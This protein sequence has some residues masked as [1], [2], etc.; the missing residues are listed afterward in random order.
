MIASFS[1]IHFNSSGNSF[2][3]GAFWLGSKWFSTPV[4]ISFN[5]WSD[6]KYCYKQIDGIYYNIARWARLWPLWPKWLE[7]LTKSNSNYS[8]L[9]MEGGL[10][11]ACSWTNNEY[12]IFWYIKYTLEWNPTTVSHLI[13]WAMLDYNTNTYSGSF[14]NN[15]QIFNNETPLWYIR[16]SLGW[17]GFIGGQI[18]G[19]QELLN[20]L[21]VTGSINEAFSLNNGIIWTTS[22]WSFTQTSTW[23]AANTML[24]ALFIQG[25]AIISKA[26]NLYE[27]KALLGNSDKRAIL[28]SSNDINAATVI[29]IAKKNAESLCRWL[30]YQT[31]SSK[32]QILRNTSSSN[33]ICYQNSPDLWINLQGNNNTLIGKTVIIQSGNLTLKWNMDSSSPSLDIFIDWGNLYVDPNWNGTATKFNVQWFPTTLN[34]AVNQGIFLKGNFVINGLL[35]G[36]QNNAPGV[37]S[38]KI[39]LQ[40]KFVSLNTPSAPSDWRVEQVTDTLWTD[41]YSGRINLENLLTRQCGLGGTGG[42]N[43]QCWWLWGDITKTPLVILDGAF[44]SKIIK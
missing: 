24:S 1:Q 11:T 37:I 27:T 33:V 44:P 28:L 22:S 3:W 39:H 42:D 12:N 20:Y 2:G 43:T 18:S 7:L 34:D 13:A 5:N 32:T 9:W 30:V 16:D 8:K 14:S 36:R 19:N 41:I 40:G 10:Y 35:L 31:E 4:K 38:N 17:I 21:N 25:N 6:V 26:L 23:S 15:L 29:N